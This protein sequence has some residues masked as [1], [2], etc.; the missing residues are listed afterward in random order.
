MIIFIQ[1]TNIFIT[2]LLCP[3]LIS[4]GVSKMECRV[5]AGDLLSRLLS[6][7]S[8]D[9]SLL[10]ILTARSIDSKWWTL[11]DLNPRQPGHLSY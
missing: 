1:I 9:K 10:E 3:Q 8:R 11:G 2:Y 6:R 5:D 7:G 4:P